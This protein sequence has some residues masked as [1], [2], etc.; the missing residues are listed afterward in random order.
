MIRR[1]SPVAG[2]RMSSGVTP[3]VSISRIVIAT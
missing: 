2:S 1:G 3:N